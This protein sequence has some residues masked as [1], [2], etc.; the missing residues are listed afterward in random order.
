MK[1]SSALKHWKVN[2]VWPI[3]WTRGLLFG[4]MDQVGMLFHRKEF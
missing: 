1:S 2:V 3:S 4:C